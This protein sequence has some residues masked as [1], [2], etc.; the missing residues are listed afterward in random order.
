L[1]LQKAES[2]W[3]IE[4][5]MVRVGNHDIALQ[6]FSYHAKN[7]VA[8]RDSLRTL[9]KEIICSDFRTYQLFRMIILAAL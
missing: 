1:C 5:N 2:E 9:H 6:G 8:K 4:K 3:R 7:S